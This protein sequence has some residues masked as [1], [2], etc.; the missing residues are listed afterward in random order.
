MTFSSYR[1]HPSL[2]V[3]EK[4][5]SLIIAFTSTDTAT[6]ASANDVNIKVETVSLV[7]V[8]FC[9]KRNLF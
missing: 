6:D 3:A 9:I 7:Y 4:V 8:L 2:L 1:S 5:V